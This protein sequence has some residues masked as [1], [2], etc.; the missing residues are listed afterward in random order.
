VIKVNLNFDDRDAFFGVFLLLH[1]E[2]V[3][4]EMKLEFFI[5][6]VDAN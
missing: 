2:D 4:V 5:A 3:I 1:Q 6:I